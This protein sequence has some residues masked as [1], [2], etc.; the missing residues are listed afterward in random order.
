VDIEEVKRQESK[1]A[2]NI[3][4]WLNEYGLSSTPQAKRQADKKKKAT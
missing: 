4:K 2:A 1:Q 3:K